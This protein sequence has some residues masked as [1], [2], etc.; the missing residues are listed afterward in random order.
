MSG[1]PADLTISEAP[2]SATSTECRH[3]GSPITASDTTGGRF[4]CRGCEAAYRTVTGLG[5]DSYYQRRALDASLRPP[6]PDAEAPAV[7]YTTFV[8]DAGD[9]ERRAHLMV[10]GLHCAAC[11]WL[12][13]SLLN[14]Q[15]GVVGARIN[16]TTRRLVLTWRADVTDV[17]TLTAAVNG[18]GY[19]LA[20]FDPEALASAGA[21]R[22]R[23]L[24]RAMAVAGF[25]AGNVMLLSISVWAGHA[26]GMAAVTRDLLH[27]VSALIA[28]PAIA[29]AGRPF[30]RSAIQALAV[31]HL[32]MDVPIA[33]AVLLAA[34]MSLHQTIV[35]APHAYFD[36]AITLLFFL[37]VGRYLDS[38]ARGRAR[39]TAEHLLSLASS[40]VTVVEADGERRVVAPSMVRPGM[41]VAVAAGERV[42]VDGRVT[43]G[44]SDVDT[45]LI[46]GES[47]PKSAL[48]GQTVFAGTL[49]LTAPL[50]LEVTA[51]GEGTLLAEI[52]RLVEAAEQGRS[53]YVVLADR[54][55]RLYAPVVHAVALATFVGWWAVVGVAWQQALLY[56]VAVLIITCPCALALAVPA[57]QV[58]ATGRL[59]RRGTLVKSGTA[60]ERLAAIDTVVFDK[61]GTLTTAIPELDMTTNTEADVATLETAAELA[62]TSRHPLARALVR[63]ADAAGLRVGVASDVREIHGRGLERTTS[64][65]G[66][67]LGSG[68]FVGVDATRKTRDGAGPELWLARPGAEPV[69]FGF[70]DRPRT[71][72]V[73]VVCALRDRGMDVVLL[74]GD[75]PAAVAAT[76]TAVGI[77]DR[78]AGLAPAAKVNRL[79]D[80]TAAGRRPLMVGDGL[81]DAP[82]LATA[83]A[84][85]SPAT[86]ADISQ[87]AADV[88]FQ[89]ERLAPVVEAL[90]T[91]RRAHRL[92]RQN[93]GLAFLY[94]AIAVP[95]AVAGLV[96]PL[97][98]AV[99]MSSSSVVV[100][101]NALR[102]N[103]TPRMPEGQP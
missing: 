52:V 48:A 92:A 69:R 80:L 86:A 71:D 87:T 18:L 79:E 34:G 20:P 66:V 33:L 82:A 75:R 99:A 60:L 101:L 14:R 76:A 58:I 5:L 1:G 97:I 100:I 46:D 35:G 31:R 10:D 23:E 29:Y 88:V 21:R 91:T 19:R 73:E 90:D 47:V 26:Q 102:L 7:D 103:R 98:A 95:I 32:N 81:N 27:W 40:A 85:M 96:T 89:G 64:D 56:A 25:A 78:Q 55:A 39:G 45:A 15:P 94:N 67:R 17:E 44:A 42:A 9:G 13:E 57:V 74:S 50:T 36:S 30:F 16:M 24:L 28:L 43:T 68:T 72:A 84:S 61:T 6:R 59:L 70:V 53:R 51:A 83:H 41:T 3:C 12:I 37:L 49:N 22:E 93:I 2:E 8:R 38:R 54:I 4:C 65:G 77:G 63:A 11:V 62:A